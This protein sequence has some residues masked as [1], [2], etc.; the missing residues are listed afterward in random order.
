MEICGKV[1]CAVEKRWIYRKKNLKLY[2]LLVAE[3]QFC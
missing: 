2:Y 3:E 1:P